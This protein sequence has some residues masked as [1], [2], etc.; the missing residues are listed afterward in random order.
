MA[1]VVPLSPP[2]VSPAVVYPG[3]VPAVSPA[4]SPADMSTAVPSRGRARQKCGCSKGSGRDE[5]EE[6][7][8]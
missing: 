6:E 5:N 1:I 8:T 4:G 3:V 7:L 2:A